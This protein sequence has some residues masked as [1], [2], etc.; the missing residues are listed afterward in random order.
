LRFST[1][2][3]LLLKVNLNCPFSVSLFYLWPKDLGYF[4]C[5]SFTVQRILQSMMV[6]LIT[7]HFCAVLPHFS[8]KSICA[9]PGVESVISVVYPSDYAIYRYAH[10]SELILNTTEYFLYWR[11]SWYSEL[12]ISVHVQRRI[13]LH[14]YTQHGGYIN[15]WSTFRLHRRWRYSGGLWFSGW[16]TVSSSCLLWQSAVFSVSLTAG[17]FCK[18]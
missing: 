13:V 11:C 5:L 4:A 8:D 3:I 14:L 17:Y 2:L 7:T 9:K 1:I 10:I 6:L 15:C 18:L 16:V 12:F